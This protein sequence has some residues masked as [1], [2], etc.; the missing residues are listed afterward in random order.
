MLQ[1][2]AKLIFISS[3]NSG[4]KTTS[5]LYD[6]KDAQE[7]VLNVVNYVCDEHM[8]D[9]S[10]QDSIT[11]CPCFK[12]YIP[13]YITINENIKQTSNLLLE[14]A[15]TTELMGSVPVACKSSP[16]INELAVARFDLYR[17]ETA[18]SS[19]TTK[20][21][22]YVYIDPAYSNNTHASGTG[23]VALAECQGQQKYVILGMEHFFLRSLTGAASFHIGSCALSLIRC[24][25]VQHPWISEIR[26]SVEGNSN[27]DSGVAI[28]TYISDNCPI[29]IL[30]SHYKDKKG[31]R[32]PVYMLGSEKSLAFEFFICSLNSGTLGVSQ[33]VVSN[34]IQLSYDPVSYLIEQIKNIKSVVQSSG[35]I[36]YSSKTSAMSDDVLIAC[37]MALYS[38]RGD[39]GLFLD[40]SHVTGS[41]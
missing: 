28:S 14:D 3:V 38:T 32:W 5:F 29:P 2:D 17:M 19:P 22:L 26:C 13:S 39:R 40:I 33:T 15:F 8:E 25:L 6:L 31:M 4:E 27:Q 7:K 9:F 18:S 35:S 10:K 36:A 1:K 23:I 34:T 30:F 41:G 20:G 16:V 12:L 37:V 21:V 24:V 11:A